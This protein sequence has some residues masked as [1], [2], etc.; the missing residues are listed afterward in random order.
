MGEATILSA[1]SDA[2]GTLAAAA[3]AFGMLRLG[4]LQYGLV[5]PRD[6]EAVPLLPVLGVATGGAAG[7]ALLLAMPHAAAFSP[8]GLFTTGSP[9][10]VTLG[11]F[12][13]RYALPQGATLLELGK[14]VAGRAGWP[15]VLTAWAA[16]L[17][18]LAGPVLAWRL[19]Q[20]SDRARALGGFLLLALWTALILHYTAHLLAWVLAQLNFWAFGLGL[21]LFQRWRC[22]AAVA[23]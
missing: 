8:L 21:L 7:L 18:L 3:L 12:L 23:H 2:V 22:R 16:L 11:G 17:G 4:S 6:A 1:A 9:W 10:E 20:G 14:A 19:W 15:Q 13:G 5:A